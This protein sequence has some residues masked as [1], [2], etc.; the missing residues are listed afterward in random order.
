MYKSFS[1]KLWKVE[2]EGWL[3]RDLE[4]KALLLG[5]ASG[6]GSDFHSCYNWVIS[7]SS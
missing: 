2:K 3:A 1:R 6:H 5:G 7:S 4:D